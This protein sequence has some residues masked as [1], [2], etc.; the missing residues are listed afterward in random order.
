MTK[1]KLMAILN[2]TAD[3]F[4]DGGKW[5][6]HE[7]ALAQAHNLIDEGADW[8]DIGG[9]SSRPGAQPITVEEEKNRVIPLISA[10]SKETDIPIS[11]DTRHPETAE[12]ALIA[13]AKMINDITGFS[14]PKMQKLA[15]SSGSMLCLMHMQGT[16]QTMQK[17]PSYP[18][19]VITHLV[20]FFEKKISELLCSGVSESN[21]IIDPGI[22]FGK[23]VAHNLE[24]IQNLQKLKDLGM[25]VLLGASRK[26]FMTKLIELPAAELLPTSLVVNAIGIINGADYIRVHDASEHRRV[27]DF[28][29]SCKKEGFLYE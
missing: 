18:E 5:N 1:P 21:I 12:A 17:K 7:K 29:A 8:I 9:E 15:A 13:G 10:L 14:N 16:P 2:V 27:I 3:S 22:G 19:G 6:S 20:I 23:T 24:I 25:P 26:S 28:L 11:I 4:Y